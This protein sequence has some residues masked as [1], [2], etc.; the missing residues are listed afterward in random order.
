MQGIAG[1]AGATGAQGPQGDAG[2][3]SL[4]VQT[5]APTSI[6]PNGG[7]EL[8]SGLDLDGDGQLED[9]EVTSTSYVCDG[10]P[11]E[12]GPPG[13]AGPAGPQGQPGSSAPQSGPP[14]GD[15]GGNLGFVCFEGITGS[16]ANSPVG[17]PGAWSELTGFG[18]SVNVPVSVSSTATTTGAP[19]FALDA[20]LVFDQATPELAS[21]NAAG[22]NINSVVLAFETAGAVPFVFFRVTLTNAI[23]SSI[24]TSGASATDV[25]QV[26]LV[27]VFDDIAIEYDAQNPD[28]TVGLATAVEWDVALRQGAPPATGMPVLDFV[29]N[30]PATAPFDVASSFSPPAQGVG[31]T[32]P[33]AG[34]DREVTQPSFTAASVALPVDATI[35]EDFAWAANGSVFTDSTV[36]LFQ[37]SGGTPTQYASYGFPSPVVESITLSGLNA[38]V[39]FVANQYSL[40]AGSSTVQLQE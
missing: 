33:A 22:Q 34:Q 19:S 21:A 40:T 39:V 26:S 9:A 11:G 16:C 10:A 2:P 28:G 20:S 7:T 13:P 30:S 14:I 1:E 37:A 23:I 35:V 38:T 8:Q 3:A 4:L 32:S 25:P 18:L 12:V 29:V 36:E 6:C 15:L 27:L 24:T 5:A 31:V 17:T